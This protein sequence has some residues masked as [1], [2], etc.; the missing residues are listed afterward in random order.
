MDSVEYSDSVFCILLTDCRGK[1]A[2]GEE[3]IKPY[4]PPTLDSNIGYLELAIKVI[5]VNMLQPH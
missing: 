5:N 4:T 3:V 1:D 2:T